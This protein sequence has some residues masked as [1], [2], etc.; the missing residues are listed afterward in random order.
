MTERERYKQMAKA[1]GVHE[2]M[3]DFA[4]TLL[5]IAHKEKSRGEKPLSDVTYVMDA[6]GKWSVMPL[7]KGDE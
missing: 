6:E 2:S 5:E 7:T 1:Q 3:L 4:A